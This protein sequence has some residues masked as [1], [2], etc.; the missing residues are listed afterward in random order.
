[1]PL[2]GPTYGQLRWAYRGA[3]K[4][5][6]RV[7][8]PVRF[9]SNFVPGLGG[10]KLGTQGYRMYRGGRALRSSRR[11]TAGKKRMLGY[12][13]TAKDVI[14]LA[15]GPTVTGYWHRKKSKGGSS[16]KSSQQNGGRKWGKQSHPPWAQASESRERTPAR[17][18]SRRN[19]FFRRSTQSKKWSSAPYCAI[20]KRRHWCWY[21]RKN[22]K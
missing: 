13:D 18:R 5:W 16:S 11:M 19:T 1:M 10:I 6:R 2:P 14:F 12:A 20:H 4:Q 3:R 22:K 9:A 17:R 8:K 15:A 7:P 21:T